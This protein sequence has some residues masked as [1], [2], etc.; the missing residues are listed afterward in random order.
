SPLMAA[1]DVIR[2]T[3]GVLCAL[4]DFGGLHPTAHREDFL[5]S[6]APMC[7]ALVAGPPA[8]RVRQLLALMDAGL[9]RVVGPEVE[10]AGDSA[11]GRFVVASPKVIGSSTPVDVVVD[12][13]VPEPDL[14]ADPAPLT[15]NLRSRGLWTEFVNRH[16][17]ETFPTG[18]VAVTRAPF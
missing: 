8:I 14:D 9:L 3:R 13:R 12:A 17:D 2:D 11:L 5:G 15:R 6:Y 18:G 16:G 1:L 4:V 10:I 7:S